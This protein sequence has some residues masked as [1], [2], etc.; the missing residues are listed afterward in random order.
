MPI[1]H[2][3]LKLLDR[4]P[5]QH[6]LVAG[7]F[8]L[9]LYLSG[10]VSRISPE[11][12][13][14]VVHVRDRSIKVGGAGNVALN[15]VALG[16]KVRALTVIG[17]DDGGSMLIEKLTEQSVDTRFILQDASHVTSLKT[18]IVAQN[19]QILRYDEEEI[20]AA[21]DSIAE[22]I[23]TDIDRLFEGIHGVIL[24]DYG[25]GF[26]TEA[27]TSRLITEAKKRHLPVFVDPKGIDFGKYRGADYCTPNLK[28]L[29]GA[30]GGALLTCEEE[31]QEAAISL[32]ENCGL[33]NL[34]V[35]R[36]EKGI[37]YVNGKTHEKHDFPAIAKEVSDV[38]GAG[39][40]VISTMT[41]A[42]SAGIDIDTCCIL[43]NLAAS[44]VVSKFGAAVATLDELREE[45]SLVKRVKE[46]KQCSK[47]EIVEIVK[48]LQ[49]QGQTVVFTNG[50]FD[51]VHAG[52]IASFRK[53]KEMGDVL[54]VAVNS[55][56]SIRRLKGEERPV[57]MLENRMK[58]LEA[59]EMIDYLVPFSEDTPQNL[60]EAIRP[61][62]LVKGADWKGKKVAGEDFIK[63]YGGRIAFIDLE[64][65]LS[66][67]NLV[68]KIRQGASA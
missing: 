68:A 40:T 22:K 26:L 64:E 48:S 10:S 7:D 42:C 43:A 45:L 39:D 66:T 9:D 13:V 23:I 55:D 56:D 20:N 61:D 27:I 47:Q 21:E 50:C 62:V 14:P 18:R 49:A 4:L 54:I 31:I 5:G 29:S 53:A 35:T 65:G 32:C 19:Q 3:L 52:H 11:A 37:S 36:S 51:L 25:K 15:I 6:I 33:E 60:I 44:I 30:I 17:E 12:P 16:G 1:Q 59:L 34:I 46:S 28:E 24:S 38:T 57:V 41:M 2:N 8:M 67:T 63:S 58:L